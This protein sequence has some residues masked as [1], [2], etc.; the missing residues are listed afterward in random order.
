MEF[1][2]QDLAFWELVLDAVALL[3]CTMAVVGL[4]V[5]RRERVP[6]LYSTGTVP[7]HFESL[8]KRGHPFQDGEPTGEPMSTA[9]P[10]FFQAEPES[11]DSGDL[12]D[13][14]LQLAEGGMSVSAVAEEVG[15]P[16]GEVELALK[17]RRMVLP[18]A[19]FSGASVIPL[20]DS[21]LG[22]GALDRPEEEAV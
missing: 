22:K 11:A 15:L 4:V 14:A 9:R 18:E 19:D 17:F 10:D 21:R 7:G 20:R 2:W 5:W 12:Y 6:V 13:Q 8:E 1:H 16:R 3:L